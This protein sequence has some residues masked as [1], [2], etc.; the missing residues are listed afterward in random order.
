M[1]I[2]PAIFILLIAAVF[3]LAIVVLFIIQSYNHLIRKVEHAEEEKM[4]LHDSLN[5]KATQILDEAHE[6]NLKIL[7]EA[8]R[9]AAAILSEA[10]LSKTATQAIAK[11]KLDEVLML[12]KKTTDNLNQQFSKNYEAALNKLQSEDVRNLEKITHEVEE[13]VSREMQ[14]FTKTLKSETV[15]AHAI[16]QER[17]EQEYAKAEQDIDTYKKQQIAKIDASVY[18]LLKKVINLVIGKSLTAQDHELLVTEAIEE[19]SREFPTSTA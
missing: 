5:Q 11:E 16:M 4:H 9:Q 17:I 6:Q 15:D 1:T 10:T 14:D 2:N 18:P 13:T 7:E 12:Q 8:N 19:A 3:G